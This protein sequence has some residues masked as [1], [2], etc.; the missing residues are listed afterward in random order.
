[1]KTNDG[2]ARVWPFGVILVGIGGRPMGARM[3]TSRT[4]RERHRVSE[5]ESG[6]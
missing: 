2:V 1:M 4:E 3:D 6:G 5:N